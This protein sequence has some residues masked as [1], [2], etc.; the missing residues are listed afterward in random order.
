MMLLNEFSD[1][2]FDYY[3]NGN[4]GTISWIQSPNLK[5]N[6]EVNVGVDQSSSSTGICI[7]SP[8][9]LFLTELPREKEYMS[10]N[11]YKCALKKELDC[12]L[13]TLN[14]KHFI[15]E[16][17]KHITPL[18]SVINEITEV[19]KSYTKT[20]NKDSVKIVSIA[21]PVWRKGFFSSSDYSGEYT[22]QA[23]KSACVSQVL[24]EQPMTEKFLNSSHKDFDAYEAYGIINGYLRMNYAEDGTRIVN[25]SMNFRNGR[26]YNYLLFKCQEDELDTRIK[27]IRETY[28]RKPTDIILSNKELLLENS[29]NRIIG[30]YDEAILVI[31]EHSEF[32][33]YIIELEQH[34][35]DGDIFIV[36]VRRD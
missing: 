36:Y 15:Y 23:I 16:K 5:S 30:E 2:Q 25:T 20:I 28:C 11:E 24:A 1:T 7:Q 35:D 31:K 33:A 27:Y 6:Y 12:L 26:K 29:L 32:P 8:D 9:L 14:L 13:R 17:H 22:R 34:Y 21:P 18:D 10:I 4:V 3:L 19:L